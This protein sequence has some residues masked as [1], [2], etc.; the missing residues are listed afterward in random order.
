MIVSLIFNF[1]YFDTLLGWTK[2]TRLS[3]SQRAEQWKT[4]FFHSTV[5]LGSSVHR[6]VS[7]F[8][9]F[10]DKHLMMPCSQHQRQ[11]FPYSPPW[12]NPL[13]FLLPPMFVIIISHHIPEL[14]ASFQGVSKEILGFNLS[15]LE[16]CYQRHLTTILKGRNIHLT[17][18]LEPQLALRNYRKWLYKLVAVPLSPYSPP[19]LSL[20]SVALAH[21]S[22]PTRV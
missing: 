20:Y 12:P 15:V 17:S 2:Q 13:L 1:L 18:G 6:S 10:K 4:R 3:P 16:L 14:G 8:P 22:S 19:P 7:L 21:R 5:F 9:P 11:S